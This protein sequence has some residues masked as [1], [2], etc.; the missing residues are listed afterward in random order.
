MWLG[1]FSIKR[2]L[3]FRVIKCLNSWWARK[4]FWSSSMP[5]KDHFFSTSKHASLL[6]LS[7]SSFIG[8][9]SRPSPFCTPT[10]SLIAILNSKIYLYTKKMIE[11]S[12]SK[13]VILDFPLTL[14]STRLSYSLI[15]TKEPRKG[16]CHLR[17]LLANN[18][19]PSDMI[20]RKQISS[21]LEFSYSL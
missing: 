7:K 13:S 5:I 3:A 8:R 9:L 4:I 15:S 21:L 17:S 18:Q 10:I 2:K 19:N 16:I 14:R 1:L 20:R 12:P 11:R 6:T